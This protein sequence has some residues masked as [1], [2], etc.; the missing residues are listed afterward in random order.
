MRPTRATLAAAVAILLAA[1]AG[2]PRRAAVPPP[3]TAPGLP[4]PPPPD[5]ADA[6]PRAEPRSSH[7]NPPFYDVN[8]RRY[9]VLASADDYF[10]RGVAS[11]Y[12]PD[13]QGLCAAW[14]RG[15]KAASTLATT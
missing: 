14:K 11:W 2:A 5:V 15:R 10:E 7:G 12:G 4:T 9:Q 13:F 3:A 8:G 1:C 6:V